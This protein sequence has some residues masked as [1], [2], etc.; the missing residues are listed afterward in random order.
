MVPVFEMKVGKSLPS[1]PRA[2]EVMD[3]TEGAQRAGR[4]VDGVRVV[5]VVV[6]VVMVEVGAGAVAVAVIVLTAILVSVFVKREGELTLAGKVVPTV[7]VTVVV[8]AGIERQEQ[9]WE[10]CEAAK[11]ET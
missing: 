10:T 5:V 1:V 7:V 3:R 2:P 9:A 4:V 6:V 11:A 8:L